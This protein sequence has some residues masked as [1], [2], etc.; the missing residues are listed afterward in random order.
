MI[1]R[2]NP[3]IEHKK[4]DDLT[5][6]INEISELFSFEDNG[7]IKYSPED[8]AAATLLMCTFHT[9]AETIQ[10]IDGLPS[11]DRILARMSEEKALDLGEKINK[12][13]KRRVLSIDFP[14]NVK[15]IVAGD[16]T[17]NSFYGDKNN[18]AIMGGKNKAGTNYFYKFLTFSITVKGHR[19]PV[20]FYPLTQLRLTKIDDIIEDEL[21]WLRDNFSGKRFLFD[22]GFNSHK[23]YNNIARAGGEFIMPFKRNKKLNKIFEDYKPFITKYQK[24]HGFILK[25]YH[26]NGWSSDYKIVVYWLKVRGSSK[27]PK[28]KW[29]FFI[30]NMNLKPSSIVF[31]YKRRWGVET[32][33]SQ[34]HTLQAFTNSRKF[35][36]RVFLIGIAFLLFANW[37]YLNWHLAI[38]SVNQR[39]KR[40]LNKPTISLKRFKITVSLPKFRVILMLGLLDVLTQKKE[41]KFDA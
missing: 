9:S 12:M 30:T 34:I 23:I 35:N 2:L 19:F 39:N 14:P 6:I 1:S 17:E 38:N 3:P 25:G 10:I 37:V 16:L 4:P 33:Y 41:K 26:S 8:V 24:K 36:V 20:G 32:A 18:P 27:E 21:V 5:I 22:R 31:I 11:A 15:I 29:V 40:F 13:L 28:W 7:K